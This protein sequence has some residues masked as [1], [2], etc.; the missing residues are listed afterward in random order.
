MTVLPLRAVLSLVLLVEPY[1]EG[2]LAGISAGL[3]P[4]NI[5]KSDGR[6]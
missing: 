4:K 1:W 5:N 6:W 2:L 3:T